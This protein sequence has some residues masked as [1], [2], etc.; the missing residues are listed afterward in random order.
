MEKMEPYRKKGMLVGYS[1]SSKTY[2]IYVLGERHIE[3]NWDVT[4]HEEVAFK[5][6]KEIQYDINME[7]HDTSMKKDPNLILSI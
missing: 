6:S 2:K 3:V 7:E 5:R 1:E 4:F